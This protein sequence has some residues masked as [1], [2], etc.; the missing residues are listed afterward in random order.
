ANGQEL[1]LQGFGGAQIKHRRKRESR[2]HQNSS[3]P[4]SAATGAGLR[5]APPR[6]TV[7]MAATVWATGWGLRTCA[8]AGWR[9]ATGAAAWPVRKRDTEAARTS[10]SCA[11]EWLAAVDCSTI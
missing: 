4:S 2:R 11:S 8:G 9:A 1:G 5:A 7:F 3:Q 6:P 10:A